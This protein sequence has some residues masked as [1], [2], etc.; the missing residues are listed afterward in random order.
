MACLEV[1]AA[2]YAQQL[3]LFLRQGDA[4]DIPQGGVFD[5][6]LHALAKGLYRVHV[7]ACD[8]LSPP[9]I[10]GLTGWSAPEYESLLLDKFGIDAVV[11]P[12]TDANDPHFE[13]VDDRHRFRFQITLKTNDDL[14]KLEQ[15]TAYLNEYKQL[16]TD[17]WF[18]A[19]DH[20]TSFKFPAVAAGLVNIQGDRNI[21]EHSVLSDVSFSPCFINASDS[22]GVVLSAKNSQQTTCCGFI[23]GTD[24]GNT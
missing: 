7:T 6:L 11:H 17:Y 12:F 22:R 4:W 14:K 18:K 2:A 5:R 24:R 19:P 3:R 15:L 23:L 16:H 1:N 10:E 20:H 9:D 13:R 8:A 21:T